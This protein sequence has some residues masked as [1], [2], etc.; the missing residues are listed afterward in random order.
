MSMKLVKLRK[1]FTAVALTALVTVSGGL[2]FAQDAGPPADLPA[3]GEG[4]AGEDHGGTT[5][6]APSV[7]LEEMNLSPGDM[8]TRADEYLKQMKDF[9]KRAVQL[10]EIAKRQKDIVR[11]NCVNDRLLQLKQLMNIAED[12]NTN[13]GMAIT[14]SDDDARKSEFARI[15][16]ARDQGAALAAEA[17]QC[18]GTDFM[19]FEGPTE[20]EVEGGDEPDDPTQP[21]DPTFPEVV[22]PP[23]ASPF[24]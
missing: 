10:Q 6:G 22:A 23:S 14:R 11:L 1:A 20:V 15:S 12:A 21:D 16:V 5:G 8:V 17:E 19:K 24:V 18:V 3:P 7:D 13:L 4:A 2:V 9:L